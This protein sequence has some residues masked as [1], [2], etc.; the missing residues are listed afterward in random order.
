M[1]PWAKAW[2]L[3]NT[4]GFM[5]SC[6][7][8]LYLWAVQPRTGLCLNTSGLDIFLEMHG[9]KRF[10]STSFH[11]HFTLLFA[12]LVCW[13]L[14][15]LSSVFRASSSSMAALFLFCSNLLVFRLPQQGGKDPQ[16]S[17][18]YYVLFSLFQAKN[19]ANDKKRFGNQVLWGK[20][21]FFAARNINYWRL[22]WEFGSWHL[23]QAAAPQGHQSKVPGWM[24]WL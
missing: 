5:W 21:V 3:V 18:K 24:R 1:A 9:D 17:V 22:I 20:K 6:M 11:P 12:S 2:P 16:V 13:E 8:W 14:S 15:M 23:K 4:K 7:L 19:P 10:H